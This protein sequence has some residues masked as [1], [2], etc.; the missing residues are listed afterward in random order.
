MDPQFVDPRNGNFELRDDSPAIDAGT[1]RGGLPARDIDGDARV[2]GAVDI[3][4]QEQGSSTGGSAPSTYAPPEFA[5]PISFTVDENNTS[6]GTLAAQDGEAQ[7]LAYSIEGGADADLFEIDGATGALNFRAA[8][9]F[10]SAQDANGDNVYEIAV[11]ADD[12]TNAPVVADVAVTVR[13]VEETSPEPAPTPDPEPVSASTL[14]G[15]DARPAA[16]E[17]GDPEGYELGVKFQATADGQI[18]ALRYWRGDADSW[19]SDTRMLN[20]W[21]G[22]GEKLASVEVI[23]GRGESGWQT[24][25]IAN[26]VDVTAGAT[27]V[28]SYG[29]QD[30]YANTVNYFEHGQTTNVD[31]TLALP[32][33][34]MGVFETDIGR[35]PTQ[36]WNASN[37]W[38]DVVF[39]PGDAAALTEAENLVIR[40]TRGEDDLQGGDGDDTISGGSGRDHLWGYAGDDELRGEGGGDVLNGGMGADDLLGGWRDDLFVYESASDSRPGAMDRL[41]DFGKG[42]DRIDLTGLDAI[43]GGQDDAFSWIDG[44]GF[45]NQPGELRWEGRDGTVVLQGDISGNG[46]ADLAI[47]IAGV[48]ELSVFDILL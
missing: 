17:T 7:D 34:S 22:A 28:A 30:N 38:A 1:S 10:E 18:T 27:Y 14:F 48:S 12:G 39:A 20:L 47:Q 35:Y 21:T 33:G 29:T 42:A 16:T 37:Y 15:P 8:P 3:G 32:S 36:T 41:L 13:E 40:G 43:A 2:V 44:S 24:A 26:A 31:G 4:A 45:H 25:E 46:S 5:S 19:D 23:S 6:V 9:D 11:G